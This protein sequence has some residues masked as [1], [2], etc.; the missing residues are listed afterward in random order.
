MTIDKLG[1]IDPLKNVQKTLRNTGTERVSAG[2]DS[3]D[4]SDEARQMAETYYLSE[5]AAGTPDV[6]ADRVAQVKQN[7]QDPGYLNTDVLS[8]AAEKIMESFGL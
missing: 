6:R 8:S 5:V 2:Y 3:I 4:I 7:I 1:G